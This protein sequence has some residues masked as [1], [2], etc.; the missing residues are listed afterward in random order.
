M[1]IYKDPTGRF[2]YVFDFLYNESIIA[3][4]RVV[5][6]RVGLSNF[7]FEEGKWRFNNLDLVNV[8]CTAYPLT[9]VDKNMYDDMVL[10]EAEKKQ[11]EIREKKA[12]ELKTKLHSDLRI[13]GMKQELRP[14]Q[15]VGVEFFD[16][17]GGKAILADPMGCLDGETIVYA[18]REKD[19]EMQKYRMV[20]LFKVFVQEKK[21][22][23]YEDNPFLSYSL[24]EKKEFVT[25]EIKNILWKGEKKCIEL[26]I[27]W[28]Q[29]YYQLRLTDDH[30]LLSVDRGW[31]ASGKLRL[32]ERVFL[33]RCFIKNA[34]L[35]GRGTIVNKCDS[36][37]TDVFDIVMKE[38]YHNF[39]ANDIVVHNCGKT[40]QALGY[41]AY[42]G[43][44]KSLIVCT[45]STKY[46]W[47]DEVV[48][49]TKLR[50]FVVD[51]KDS[52]LE[53]IDEFN[54]HD[55]IIINYD[56]IK[57]NF[58]Y[59][60]VYA[61]EIIVLDEFQMI[62]NSQAQRTKLVKE[63]ASGRSR[64]LLLSGTPMLSRP[65][66]LF[67]GLNLIDPYTWGSYYD[68]TRR[69]CAGHKGF[70]GWEAKGATHIDELQGRISKYFL[71]RKKEDILK[72]LPPKNYIDVPVKLDKENMQDYV[73]AEDD[74]IE[75]LIDTKNKK[76]IKMSKGENDQAN[77]LVKLN[78]LRQITSYGKVWAAKELIE[79]LVDSDEKVLVFSVY[80][81]PLN[82]LQ[83]AF[84]EELT[85]MITG[86]T[87][88]QERREIVREFQD[89]K[90]KK[91]I[92]LGG[93]KSA[94][95]GITLTAA[96]NVI[97]LDY[98]W[99]PADHDQAADR[100][101][102]IGQTASNVNIYQLFSKGTIDEDMK[103]ILITKK[104][105]FTRLIDSNNSEENKQLSLIDD[106]LKTI[107]AKRK[108]RKT[109]G[110]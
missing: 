59:L 66:E 46:S 4:C 16:N 98:S 73:E 92:F 19:E 97:F 87:S 20:D 102:R 62:K 10:F 40:A 85:C 68:Y 90:S 41:I 101:H 95:V 31:M 65:V 48:K 89:P 93:I 81:G 70:W 50:P 12:M 33:N 36:F 54:R 35:F 6:E 43:L 67:N 17:A 26:K 1:R 39:L 9:E 23:G 71:R 55:V 11:R 57:K 3:F 108:H 79:N 104:K 86:E 76:R 38:P 5:K 103:D 53:L 13:P 75:F 47:E 80:H 42:A 63:I 106:L 96:S 29:K 88:A 69:Y 99:V 51:A 107:E 22:I 64:V 110:S 72:E 105:L 27:L 21:K 2:N 44:K 74:M 78:Q 30:E 83:E 32:G 77:K 100:V 28:G 56:L 34:P 37:S 109:K 15:K 45:A 84:G 61:W 25:N 7:R 60:K 24:N 58:D 52:G 82:E 94:G 91:K 49:W 18:K 14:Y 8:I